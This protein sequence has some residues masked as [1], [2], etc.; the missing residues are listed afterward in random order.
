MAGALKAPARL[1]PL[2]A[3]C[4]RSAVEQQARCSPPCCVHRRPQRRTGATGAS[5]PC[6]G[7]SRSRAITCMRVRLRVLACWPKQAGRTQCD[8][9]NQIIDDHQC[10]RAAHPAKARGWKKAQHGSSSA[11]A[12]A[13]ATAMRLAI[14]S[15][16]PVF[17]GLMSTRTLEPHVRG[18]SGEAAV[19][20]RP[21]AR[22]APP[23]PCRL[24][25]RLECPGGQCRMREAHDDR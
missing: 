1:A 11:H 15:P 3:R 2:R 22:S 7:Q 19:T 24:R 16:S 20:V 18:G 12:H 10:R 8:A 25:A 21:D 14:L 6:A 17:D 13:H 23:H 9:H 5:E 4:S